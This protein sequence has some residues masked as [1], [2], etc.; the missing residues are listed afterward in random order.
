MSTCILSPYEKDKEKHNSIYYNDSY[1][2][3]TIASS[4]KS[5]LYSND[6]LL[7][8]S[9]DSSIIS[10]SNTYSN[11]NNNK[12]KSC[13]NIPSRVRLNTLTSSY[14]LSPILE[15]R[16]LFDFRSTNKLISIKQYE[17]SLFFPF[18]FPC[19]SEER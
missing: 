16:Q 5:T 12:F 6:V 2:K 10:E 4:N 15:S 7:R 19:P 18:N 14:L 13:T 8:T 3:S 17:K 9:F 1:R 11:D